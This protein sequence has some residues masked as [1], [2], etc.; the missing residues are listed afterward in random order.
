M[1][2]IHTPPTRTAPTPAALANI[3]PQPA[4]VLSS[5]RPEDA[6]AYDRHR[7]ERALLAA[8]LRHSNER[9]LGMVLAHLAGPGGYMP[10]GGM[11]HAGRLA[12]VARLTAR[13]T[14]ISLHHLQIARLIY[15]PDIADWPATDVV[16]PITLTMPTAAVTHQ[17][18]RDGR[19]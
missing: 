16:R 11:Q 15:R 14:R 5:P 8:D 2:E 1:T 19:L 17:P 9:L 10:A 3:R 18:R 4:P 12:G 7:W 6:G 13:Q